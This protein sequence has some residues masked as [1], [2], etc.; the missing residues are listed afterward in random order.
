MSIHKLWCTNIAGLS[1]GHLLPTGM[2][3]H[4]TETRS[5]LQNALARQEDISS[6]VASGCRAHFN[7]TTNTKIKILKSFANMDEF[8]LYF[9]N[10]KRASFQEVTDDNF[11]VWIYENGTVHYDSRLARTIQP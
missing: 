8:Q 6:H 11:L 1:N 2:G 3:G 4:A 10:A 7:S 9:A 5:R